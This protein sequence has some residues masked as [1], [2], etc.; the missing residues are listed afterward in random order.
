MQ[1][2]EPGERVIDVSLEGLLL[3]GIPAV[4]VPVRDDEESAFEGGADQGGEM[5]CM[6]GCKEEGF[7]DGI[8]LLGDCPPHLIADPGGPRLAGED[9]R[10][11]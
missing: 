8:R 1:R 5:G 10:E 11:I 4:R 6:V 3:V 2:P 9:R 7:G